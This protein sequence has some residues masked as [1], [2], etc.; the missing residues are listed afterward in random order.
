LRRETR[1]RETRRAREKKRESVHHKTHHSCN[2]IENF[3]IY[4]YII[5]TNAF[6]IIVLFL[7]VCVWVQT[8]FHRARDRLS[9]HVSFEKEIDQK[10]I[11]SQNLRHARERKER[12]KARSFSLETKAKKKKK[13]KKREDYFL[14]KVL[15]LRRVRFTYSRALLKQYKFS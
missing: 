7:C 12:A 13:I 10:T 8:D 9:S 5:E 3:L 1:E 11:A 14:E 6:K 2:I 4:I 15:L